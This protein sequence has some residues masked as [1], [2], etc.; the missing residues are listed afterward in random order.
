M[1]FVP[2]RLSQHQPEVLL[3][4]RDYLVEHPCWPL[5]CADALRAKGDRVIGEVRNAVVA[6]RLANEQRVQVAV[7]TLDV[8]KQI[9]EIRLV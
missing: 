4:D 9:V 8:S 2:S 3:L 7:L 6:A 5:K 1:P